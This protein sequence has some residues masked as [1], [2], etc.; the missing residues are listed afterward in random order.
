MSTKI[1][2]SAASERNYTEK[3]MHVSQYLH[4][5]RIPYKLRKRIDDYYGHRFE[6]KAFNED[7]ILDEMSPLLRSEV[8]NFNCMRLLNNLPLLDFCSE[9]M[10][11]WMA[12]QMDFES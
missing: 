1:K 2:S 8:S 7:D 11:T 12:Q 9:E 4:F 6:S 5:R 3:I 10:L